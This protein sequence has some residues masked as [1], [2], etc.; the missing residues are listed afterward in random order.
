MR[1][2]ICAALLHATAALVAPT[3]SLPRRAHRRHAQHRQ[4]T[5]LSALPLAAAV[6]SAA[7]LR[8]DAYE[9]CANYAAPASLVAGAVASFGA[10]RPSMAPAADRRR[11]RVAKKG[12]R[13]MLISAFTLEILAVFI[14]TITGTMLLSDGSAAAAATPMAM[15]KV[16]FELEYLACRVCFLQGLVNWLGAIALQH[17]IPKAGETTST[18]RINNFVSSS[19]CT[20]IILMAA[21]YNDH[22]EYQNYARCSGGSRSSSRR[23]STRTGRRGSCPLTVP[24]LLTTLGFRALASPQD[25]DNGAPA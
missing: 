21:I 7:E 15:L 20:L 8:F 10:E 2:V 17:A 4:P 1:R 22:T 12:V 16:T 13:L 11:V 3:T 23:A 5:R 24:A 18:R 9:W 19:L 25:D 14:T 6:R